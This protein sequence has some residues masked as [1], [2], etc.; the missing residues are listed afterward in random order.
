MPQDKIRLIALYAVLPI[1]AF[2]AIYTLWM[3]FSAPT[4][5]LSKPNDH[6]VMFVQVDSKKPEITYD[7]IEM[8]MPSEEVVVEHVQEEAFFAKEQ[9]LLDGIY[10][11]EEEVASWQKAAFE[12]RESLVSLQK[13][14]H[15]RDGYIEELK[16]EITFLDDQLF[17]QEQQITQLQKQQEKPVEKIASVPES[18]GEL[19]TR[20]H[21]L[22]EL[23]ESYKERLVYSEEHLKEAE[24][25][26]EILAIQNHDLI[27][28]KENLSLSLLQAN[29]KAQAER[30][31]LLAKDSLF[32]QFKKTLEDQKASLH[33]VEK[34]CVQLTAD[35]D[36]T[37]PKTRV[38]KEAPKDKIF[39]MVKK[40]ETLSEIS[41]LYYG[42]STG[43]QQ[44]YNANQ[45]TIPDTNKLKV[46]TLLMIPE[47]NK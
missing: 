17:Q 30:D 8:D 40:G 38:T 34:T 29:K 20:V 6:G 37:R 28:D 46:G 22:E 23:V 14:L 25:S 3:S 35:F 26:C 4:E 13:A 31:R 1:C 16:D 11:L 21:M 7:S 9:E 44:I 36:A 45:G 27:N 43:W 32:Q 15:Q 24:E 10:R 18:Q 41:R 12:A 2:V 5:S 39:H 33:D 42:T 47:N 19:A